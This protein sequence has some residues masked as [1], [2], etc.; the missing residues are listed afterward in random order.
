MQEGVSVTKNG[1]NS[2]QKYKYS[3]ESDILEVIKDK[4]VKHNLVIT[5]SVENLQQVGDI[6]NVSMKFTLVDIDSGEYASFTY[7]GSGQDKGDKGLYK[8]YTGAMKY[9]LSK[10]FLISTDDDPENDSKDVKPPVK[11]TTTISQPPMK[12]P[13]ITNGSGEKKDIWQG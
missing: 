9:F 3:T 2:F 10:T 12:I 11:T 5:N 7:W 13:K 4:L 6:T 8:A 1:Y